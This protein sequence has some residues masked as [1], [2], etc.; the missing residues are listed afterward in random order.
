MRESWVGSNVR[1]TWVEF[2]DFVCEDSECL[3]A[4]EACATTTDDLGEYEIVCEQCG[5][6][7]R[8]GNVLEERALEKQ[9]AREE[10]W[11]EDT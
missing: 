10:A 1:S 5:W 8:K 7:Y 6:S 3:Y 11:R 4:N 9:E 2:D